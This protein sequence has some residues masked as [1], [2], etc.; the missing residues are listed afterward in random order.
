MNALGILD[1][2]GIGLWLALWIGYVWWA[3]AAQRRV[4]SL[5]GAL[6]EYRRVWMHEAY[7]RENRITDVALIG[8]LAQSATFFSSIPLLLW[9]VNPWRLLAGSVVITIA[10]RYMEFRSAT[11]RALMQGRA[12]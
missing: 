2:I 8:S 3:A 7:R 1:W 6:V 9:L 12:T 10:T 4:P 11:V 5:L